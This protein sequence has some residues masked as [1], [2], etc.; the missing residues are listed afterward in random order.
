MNPGIGI[1]P[2]HSE[3]SFDYQK[4]PFKEELKSKIITT[5]KTINDVMGEIPIIGN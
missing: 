2:I 1:I 4:L 3:H 5:S